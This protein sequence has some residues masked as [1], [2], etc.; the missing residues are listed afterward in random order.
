MD[1]LPQEI[2]DHISSYLDRYDLRATLTVNSRF[3]ASAERYSGAY[4]RFDL[5]EDSAD[6]FLLTFSGRHFRHLRRIVFV[7]TLV[8]NDVPPNHRWLDPR[9]VD[10]DDPRPCRESKET[11]QE[12]D[13][14]FTKQ[15]RFL[16]DTLNTLERS[17]GDTYAPGNISLSI[18]TPI[19]EVDPTIYCPHRAY[20]SW[21]VHLLNPGGLPALNSIRRLQLQNGAEFTPFKEPV[22]TLRKI[23]L[24]ILLDLSYKLP[25]LEHLACGIGG[26]EWPTPL[27]HEVAS[28][29]CHVYQGPRRD[30]RHGFAKNFN[31]TCLPTRLRELA[32]NFIHPFQHTEYVD[33]RIA[34]PDLTAPS[35]Y[36]PFSTSLR[37]AS[38]QLRRMRLTAVVDETLFWPTD[39]SDP[40]TWPCL[41]V[42][43][44]CFHMMS[45]SG[46]WYFKGLREP[47][48]GQIRGYELE[49]RAYPPLETTNDDEYWC[50]RAEEVNW[51]D[52]S[53][54]QFRII[55]DD[56]AI[57]PFLE[58]FAKAAARMPQ[59]AYAALWCPLCFSTQPDGMGGISDYLLSPIPDHDRPGLINLVWGIAYTKP[60]QKAFSTRPGK[61]NATQRQ[62]WWLVGNR[63]QPNPQ[64]YKLFRK[65]GYQEYNNGL[66]EYWYRDRFIKKDRFNRF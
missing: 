42:L 32:L 8:T 57:S 10:E 56:E 60:R 63:W 20:V 21:R 1:N 61:D 24:R 25:N 4:E 49:E 62:I 41:E 45:P 50:D 9:D 44:V 39:G 38:Y 46:E 51:D 48:E 17:V 16:F 64:L 65:I 23:D 19:M 36:D 31:P 55:P 37:I 34:M 33:Q 26:D 47:E 13:E 52:S 27:S 11:L 53:H 29:L 12:Y 54:A 58:A 43:D 2:I 6:K 7:T 3:Q 30:S 28:H 40:P 66:L 18:L 5:D 22:I 35:L 14:S 59:L 15:I